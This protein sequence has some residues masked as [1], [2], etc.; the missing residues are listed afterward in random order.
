MLTGQ[1][2]ILTQA[3]KADVETRGA[4]VEEAKDLWENSQKV[5]EAT[6]SK[7]AQSLDELLKDY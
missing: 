4:A 3:Q 1:N 5:D 2:G 6:G 7:E